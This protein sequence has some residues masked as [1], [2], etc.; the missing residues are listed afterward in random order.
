[1]GIIINIIYWMTLIGWL[2]LKETRWFAIILIIFTIV[3]GIYLFTTT[4]YC[5]DCPISMTE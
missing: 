2:R 1:M 4:E 3:Y 5:S